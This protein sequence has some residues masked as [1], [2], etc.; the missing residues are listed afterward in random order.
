M[1]LE[2]IYLACSDISS[3]DVFDITIAN[4]KKDIEQYSFDCW[5]DIPARMKHMEVVTFSINAVN[6]FLLKP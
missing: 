4:G 2:Q 1:T 3:H 6:I 5:Y